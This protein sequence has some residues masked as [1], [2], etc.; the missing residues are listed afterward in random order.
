MASKDE[1]LKNQFDLDGKQKAANK[2]L[3]GLIEKIAHYEPLDTV[4]VGLAS[5]INF[6]ASQ[7]H[8]AQTDYILAIEYYRQAM[9]NS[10]ITTPTRYEL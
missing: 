8:Y 5:E 6:I 1:M 10:G 4:D 3:I 2:L 9:G 7:Y